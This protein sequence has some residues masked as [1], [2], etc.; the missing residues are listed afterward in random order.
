MREAGQ[1]SQGSDAEE[2]RMEHEDD[3]FRSCFG[4]E[5]DGE[6]DAGSGPL[7]RWRELL[8]REWSRREVCM[9]QASWTQ[10][11]NLAAGE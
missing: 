7:S 9:E 2:E 4:S 10:F 6:D 5:G 3:Q 11:Y 8:E 1:S